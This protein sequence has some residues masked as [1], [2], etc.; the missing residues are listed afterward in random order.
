MTDKGG[1]PSNFKKFVDWVNANEEFE[2]AEEPDE[3]EQDEH[4]Q[5]DETDEPDEPADLEAMTEMYDED[6]EFDYPDEV[7]DELDNP[8][9]A[10]D[11]YILGDFVDFSASHESVQMSKKQK[12]QM[13]RFRTF[14]FVISAVVALNIIG[15][16][17]FAVSFLPEFGAVD[18]PTVG[19]IYFRYVEEGLTDTGA[20]NLVAAVLFSYRSFDTLGEA[21]VLFTAAIGVIIMI[22]NP[23][24][25]VEGESDG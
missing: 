14:Y 13:K 11:E 8:D 6:D 17:L 12:A 9:V 15:I 24:D 19:E 4:H 2:D 21:F 3:E 20:P 16:L 5:N 18:S 23:K 25:K 7:D 10:D 22:Y 1:E